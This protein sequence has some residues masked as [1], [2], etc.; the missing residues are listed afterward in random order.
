M[1]ILGDRWQDGYLDYHRA[2]GELRVRVDCWCVLRRLTDVFLE[3]PRSL[4][5]VWNYVREVGVRQTLRKIRSR[6]AERLRDRRVVA[7]GAGE[8][9]EAESDARIP[10]GQGVLF[11]APCH[12]E[13]VERVALPEALVRPL[14][15]GAA[16]GLRRS[17]GVRLLEMPTAQAGSLPPAVDL[18]AG[19]SRFSGSEPGE[20]ARQLLDWAERE[21]PRLAQHAARELPLTQPSAVAERTAAGPA[22]SSPSAVLF[23]LGNYAKTCILPNL[24]P[25]IALRCVHEVDPTQ[26]GPIRSARYA[27]D[28]SE[29]PRPD[30]HYDVY[31]IAGYHHTHVPLAVHALRHGSWAVSEKPLAT[32]WEQLD[33]LCEA[34]RAHPGRYFAGFHMRYN[35]LWELARQDL[36]VRPGDPIHYHGIVFEVPLVARHWYNWPASRSRIVSNGCHWLDHFLFLNGFCRVAR[37]GLWRGSNGDLHLS[38][39]LENGAV[40]SLVLTDVGSRRIGVQEHVQLRAGEVTVRVDNSSR[41]MSEDRHR[42]IRRA[43]IN[44]L[45]VFGRMYREISRRI[46]EGQPGDPPESTQ[47]SCELMLLMEDELQKSLPDAG[48]SRPVERAARAAILQR[49]AG[50]AG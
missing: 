10:P 35:P 25:R 19:W 32:S 1:Y 11:V 36:G 13:C 2:P 4:R 20:P 41:Y 18:I 15:A 27:F 28:T 17:G 26:I 21:L 42:V 33:E 48:A 37:R 44:K 5:R 46:V 31:F 8:V 45:G 34:L 47:R 39:E 22:A 40:C 24:D 12:P 6:W 43:R 38:V 9:L 29:R 49:P 14:S 16:A 30:E 3:Q 7:V 50:G 23:G